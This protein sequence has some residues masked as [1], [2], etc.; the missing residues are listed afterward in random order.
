M[1][2]RKHQPEAQPDTHGHY[3]TKHN[4]VWA[5][6]CGVKKDKHGKPVKDRALRVV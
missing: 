4:D 3:F 2:K 5:C 6:A 1:G